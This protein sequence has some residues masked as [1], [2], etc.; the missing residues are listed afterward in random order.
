MAIAKVI[1]NNETLMDVTQDTVASN[2]L[3]SSYTATGADGE[4]ITGSLSVSTHVVS[5]ETVTD[6][7]GGD[8]V[9][10]NAIDISNDTVQANKLLTGYTAHD[11]FGNAITGI[12]SGGGGEIS[13][14]S[15]TATPTT[16][17]QTITA[18]TGYDGLSSVEISPIPSSYV[19]PTGTSNITQNG[20]YDVG[21]FA[22]A[23]VNVAGGSGVD[24]TP[25]IERTI[26]E[27]FYDSS[28][29]TIGSY[30]FGYCVD[31]KGINF[32]NVSH[33]DMYAFQYCNSMSYVSLPNVTTVDR[34]AFLS[35]ISL[36]SIYLPEVVHLSNS[37]FYNCSSLETI[38]LPKLQSTGSYVFNKCT[39][40]KSAFLLCESVPTTWGYV[41]NS[42]PIT[43]SSYLGYFGSIFVRAS[44]LE[45]WKVSVY[46][47]TYSARMVGLTDEEIANL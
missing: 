37:V 13:L 41:F 45:S 12:Y 35:C 24:Y 19:V 42:T 11:R 43:A 40:L 30:A 26:S 7:D 2:V 25:V 1:L 23:I 16:S 46:W 3:L 33:I 9:N 17:T 31:L 38:S 36:S 47:S 15:K 10:I 22:S 18:D 6:T 14:Q 39:S 29:H 34:Y 4:P 27:S 20:T 32:P 8:I 28:V 44:L 21:E 5:V